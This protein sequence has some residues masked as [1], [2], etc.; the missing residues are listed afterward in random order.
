[1]TGQG[2]MHLNEKRLSA[3][4]K[5]EIFYDKTDKTLEQVA[6]YHWKCSKFG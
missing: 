3:G 6:L 4:Y 2:A 1:M 5:E